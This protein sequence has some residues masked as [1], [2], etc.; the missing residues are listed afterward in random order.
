VACLIGPCSCRVLEATSG[1]VE[2]IV[3][4]GRCTTRLLAE[5]AAVVPDDGAPNAEPG[6]SHAR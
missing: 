1:E 3:E 4:R 6:R 2:R 5:Q